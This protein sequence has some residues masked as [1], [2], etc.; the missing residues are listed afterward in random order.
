[1]NPKQIL[2]NQIRRKKINKSN[3]LSHINLFD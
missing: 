2:D 1:M 3:G